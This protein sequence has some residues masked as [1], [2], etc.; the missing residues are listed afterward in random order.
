MILMLVQINHRFRKSSL[1]NLFATSGNMN[2]QQAGATPK[3]GLCGQQGG[4]HLSLASGYQQCMSECTFM[5]KT[6]TGLED[7]SNI[8]FCH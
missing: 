2:S 7:S 3:A 1:Q 8:L 6:V 4:S 5:G